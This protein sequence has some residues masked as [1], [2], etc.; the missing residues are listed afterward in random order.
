MPVFGKSDTDDLSDETALA[1]LSHSPPDDLIMLSRSIPSSP[2]HTFSLLPPCF[3]LS[4]RRCVRSLTDIM[5]LSLSLLPVTLSP[6]IPLHARP[7]DT[8]ADDK[9]AMSC[10]AAELSG[11]TNAMPSIQFHFQF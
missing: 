8:S 5:S 6:Q 4:L 7:V 9:P 11:Q 2:P 1:D 10:D 3:D